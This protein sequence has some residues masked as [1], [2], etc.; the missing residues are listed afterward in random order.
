[1]PKIETLQDFNLKLLK[2]ALNY[3]SVSAAGVA[4]WQTR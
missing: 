1:M 3:R 2:Y 4:K